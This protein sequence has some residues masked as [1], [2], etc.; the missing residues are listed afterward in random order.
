MWEEE[1]VEQ[2]NRIL[3][4]IILKE[5]KEDEWVW[6]PSKLRVFSVKTTYSLLLSQD[7]SNSFNMCE[8]P[9]FRR[10]LEM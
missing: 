9:I 6:K 5:E 4:S 1:L 7:P 2:F 10:F 8:I 3:D